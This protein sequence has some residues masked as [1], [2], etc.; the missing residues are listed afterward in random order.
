MH[1]K[2]LFYTLL[3]A[4]S[5]SPMAIAADC[6]HV[7]RVIYERQAK[8]WVSTASAKV[9]INVNA[10]AKASS[11]AAT[12]QE[13]MQQLSKIDDQSQWHI[14]SFQMSQSPSGLTS[15]NWQLSTRLKQETINHLQSQLK[16]LSS[17]GLQYGIQ[18]IS[19]EPSLEETN[20]A[21]ADLRHD[22][23]EAVQQELTTLNQTFSNN[24]YSLSQITFS[25][26]HKILRQFRAVAL[27]N[28]TQT[29]NAS[30]GHEISLLATIEL[31]S[32]AQNCT[33]KH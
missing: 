20:Q 4:T 2:Y 13:I 5:L 10:S 19:F 30:A 22:T 32:Q 3:M 15:L 14:T 24:H 18:S 27:N 26:N 8:Q 6:D 29:E 11:L 16:K 12:Q 31:A 1:K 9:V 23:Y 28:S 7:S 33:A 21:M 17:A 25:S